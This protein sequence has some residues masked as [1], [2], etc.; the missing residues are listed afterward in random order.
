MLRQC[1]GLLHFPVVSRKW[2][3]TD[4][5]RS[6]LRVTSCE[7]SPLASWGGC[8]DGDGCQTG[9]VLWVKEP[10]RLIA[11]AHGEDSEDVSPLHHSREERNRGGRSLS[12]VIS[13][14]SGERAAPWYRLCD[15]GAGRQEEDQGRAGI[16]TFL[17]KVQLAAASR[18]VS[19]SSKKEKRKIEVQ[20]SGRMCGCV[21]ARDLRDFVRLCRQAWKHNGLQLYIVSIH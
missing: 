18:H 20:S 8:V 13:F 21:S 3:T 9:N 11:H 19:V 16:I 2:V 14:S 15:T 5:P 17:Y 12:A 4:H 7:I 10:P 6:S 1:V